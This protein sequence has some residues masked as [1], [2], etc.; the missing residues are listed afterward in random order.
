MKKLL[1]SMGNAFLTILVIL[2]IVYG[3]AFIEIKLLL[4]PQPELFGYVFY[5]QQEPDMVPEF[6]PSDVIV[7]KKNAEFKSGDIILYFD[8]NDSLYKAH[9]VVSNDANGI[10]TKCATCVEDN[11]PIKSANVVGKAVGK[12][13]FMGSIIAFFKQKLVLIALAVAGIAFL[14][15]SQYIE[16]KPKKDEKSVNDNSEIEKDVA[17][18]KTN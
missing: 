17:K 8:S 18:L 9:Y 14:V 15:I 7:V 11:A 6:E 2:L 4:K 3:W 12:V 13:L 16:L 1:H 5:Q 10:V